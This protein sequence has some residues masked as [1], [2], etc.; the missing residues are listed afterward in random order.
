MNAP[1][2]PTALTSFPAASYPLD[3]ITHLTMT[4]DCQYATFAWGEEAYAIKITSPVTVY[5][6]TQANGEIQAPVVLSADRSQ[7]VIIQERTQY[8][9]DMMLAPVKPGPAAPLQSILGSAG[10]WIIFAVK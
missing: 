4:S 3:Q 6:L 5:Q 1:A 7:A 10:S 8:Q 9:P 2:T